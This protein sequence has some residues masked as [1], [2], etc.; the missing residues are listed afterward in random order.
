MR[1]A[2]LVVANSRAG[3]AAWRVPPAKGRVIH[4][5]FD[6]ERLLLTSPRRPAPCGG[7][8]TLTVVMTARMDPPKDFAAVIRAARSLAT[9]QPGRW[10]F[11]LI[12]D[13]VDRP[14]LLA[15]ASDLIEAG[16]VAFPHGGVEAIG[17]MRAADV[18]VLMSDPAILAE[19]C[20]NSIME[21]M[22]CGLPVVCADSGGSRELVE[23]GVTGFV[24]PPHDA[25]SLATTLS[26]LRDH[27]ELRAAMGAAGKARVE[28]EFT[29]LRYVD[30]YMRLYEEAMSRRR[31]HG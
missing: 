24:I 21:Y 25:V 15:S 5:A 31:G 9:S 1:F 26:Y 23:N 11:S 10:H 30:D 2:T 18:G 22:A 29:V 27:P 13:G 19:G 4:N 16:V 28:R 17:H 12:G 8:G 20:P 14:E 3:L 7:G 6:D